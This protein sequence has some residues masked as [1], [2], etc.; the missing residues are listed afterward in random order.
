MKVRGLHTNYFRRYMGGITTDTL[1]NFHTGFHASTTLIFEITTPM[2]V[3]NGSQYGLYSRTKRDRHHG[4]QL[5]TIH[6]V[7]VTDNLVKLN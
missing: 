7:L 4:A 5:Y 1:Y 3:S 6:A 2:N